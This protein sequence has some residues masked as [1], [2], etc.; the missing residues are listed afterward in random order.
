MDGRLKRLLYM[1]EHPPST[2]GG[3]PLIVRQLLGEYDQDALHVLCSRRIYDAAD[4][5]VRA[6]YLDCEHTAVGD[7]QPFDPRPRRL[8][9]PVWSTLNLARIP[10]LVRR[11]RRI[12]RERRIEAIF[13]VPW[14]CDL[15]L[16]AYL[17]SRRT[18]LPLY[19]FETDDWEAANPHTLPKL[20]TKRF[21]TPLLTRAERLWLTSPAMVRRYEDKFGRRG[22][23]L[24]HHVD[25]DRYQRAAA[26]REPF[27]NGRISLV[28]TGSINRMFID[29]MGDLCGL[30]N[31]G[32]EVDG[33]PVTLDI[34]GG[35]CPD[36]FQGPAVTWKGLVDS[37]DIPDALAAA[38]IPLIAVTFSQDED[39]VDLVKTSLYT[40]TIDYLASGR[41]VLVVSPPYSGEVD[42]FG[43]VV[44][45]VD[46]A[47]PDAL[48]SAIATIVADRERRDALS[49]AGL[50]LVRSRHSLEAIGPLFL[51]HFR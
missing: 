19:V 8:W 18:G 11:A 47:S 25:V 33:R 17:T 45:H 20:L 4:D 50:D 29:T 26:G 7:L 38:D 23:F 31:S 36:G 30:L 9:G 27:A 43:S 46:T 24:F 16:A 28:Y 12:V 34:Y 48:R 44:T 40:K 2:V 3:G 21:H 41:P 32:F 51:D 35:R 10:Y 42:Y 14:L 37:G 1:S 49:A 22:E 5:L 6:S 15:G 39:L 13:T